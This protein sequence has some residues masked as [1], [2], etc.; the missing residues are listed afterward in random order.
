MKT[1]KLTGFTLTELIVV[2]VVIGVLASIAFPRYVFVA[3]KSRTSE[4]RNILGQIREAEMGYFLE[5]DTYT[6]NIALL[7]LGLPTSCNTSFYFSYGVS[8][9]GASFTATATRC[10]S[11][12]KRP[13]SPGGTAYVVNITQNGVLGGT[14]PYV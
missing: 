10:T 9:G 12:G 1:H 14:P 11:G 4:A 8:G 2:V 6:T 7:S 3:E 13:N 5:Y